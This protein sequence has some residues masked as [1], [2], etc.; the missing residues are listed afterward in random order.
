ML[1]KISEY[2]LNIDNMEATFTI[3]PYSDGVK[4]SVAISARSYKS[5][6]VQLIM[7]EMGGGGHFNSAATQI[8]DSTIQAVKT[9][10]EVHL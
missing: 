7:E 5:V 8:F 3:A 1:A 4:E 10:L 2:I 6:N 9:E